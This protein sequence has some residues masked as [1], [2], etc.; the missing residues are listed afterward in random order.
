VVTARGS[1][2]CETCRD[3]GYVS[4]EN[5]GAWNRVGDDCGN[6]C[7]DDP[8]D[9]ADDDDGC[10]CPVCLDGGEPADAVVHDYDYK[11]RPIFHGGGPLYLGAEIEVGTP[12]GGYRACARIAASHLGRLGYLKDDSSI[13]DGF[14]IVTHPMS[15]PWA[16]DHFPWR[17]FEELRYNGCRATTRTGLHVHLSRD[18]FSCPS[19]VYRWMKF[20]YR[21]ER[22]VTTLARR[23]SPEYAAFTDS[24]RQAVKYYAKGA[25]SAR[26][27]AINSGNDDTFELR[28]FASSL[29]P[30]E[31]KA[32]LG[33]AAASVGY[34]RQLT[35]PDICRGGWGWPAFAAWLA[36]QPAYAPL[37]RQL[38][39]LSCAC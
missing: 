35:V 28:I 2:I 17:M 31:V 8:D 33:F 4:C 9:E 6:G 13:G 18:G 27:Q 23:V 16:V 30:Q 21:N 37:T 12:P 15:Y 1:V 39:A 29:D 38:E 20:I 22:Q 3:N 11:P 14:E 32:A 34:T 7:D 26:Y 10:S 36:D 24:D 19:H 5:C 25:K